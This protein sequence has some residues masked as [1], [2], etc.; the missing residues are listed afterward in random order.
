MDISVIIVNYNVEEYIIPCIQSIYKHSLSNLDFEIIVIDN[1]SRDGSVNSLKNNFSGLKIIQNDENMGFSRAVNKAF[2]YCDGKYV[3]ILNPDT[4]F[5]EDSLNKLFRV[6]ENLKD[7]GAVGPRLISKNMDHQLSFWR[8]PSIF[9]VFLSLTHLD[10]FNFK[11]NY[12][13]EKFNDLKQV[14]TISGAVIFT[15]HIIFKSLGGLNEQLFWMEDIDFC[16]RSRARNKPIY[17]TSVTKIIHYVGKSSKKNFKVS[18]SNQ[19]AS[20]VLYFKIHHTKFSFIIV[21]TITLIIATIKLIIHFLL[22][23][24]SNLSQ[25]KF[26]GYAFAIRRIFL[27]Y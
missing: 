9:N 5:V 21:A 16:V 13:N 17:F 3:L 6:A 12:R 22:F 7:F 10:A 26:F 2:K 14:E 27:N 1:N 20:K 15:P 8:D 18:I 4:L 24:F 25:K 23:P 19:L 11:K